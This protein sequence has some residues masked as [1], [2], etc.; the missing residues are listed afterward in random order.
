MEKENY[1]FVYKTDKRKNISPKYNDENGA[2]L[3]VLET[4]D[5]DMFYSQVIEKINKDNGVN[6]IENLNAYIDDIKNLRFAEVR[7]KT[8]IIDM[9]SLSIF[10]PLKLDEKFFEDDKELLEELGIYSKEISGEK[11]WNSYSN[12]INNK[13]IEYF[14]KEISLKKI[15]SILS[16]FTFS[17]AIYHG[18]GVDFLKEYGI[19]KYGYLYLEHYN[20][21][22]S[23]ENG[24]DTNVLKGIISETIF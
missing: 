15:A 3:N 21:I 11:V 14:D 18:S 24:L 12:I 16:K 2:E 23:F 10:V 5:F 9:E 13:E 19:E 17:L 20:D 1:K 6:F 22:Y 4:K 8:K 7:K